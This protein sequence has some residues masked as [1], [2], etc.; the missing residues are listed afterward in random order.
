[1]QIGADASLFGSTDL[2]FR[3]SV[4]SEWIRI[5]MVNVTFVSATVTYNKKKTKKK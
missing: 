4:M 3:A 5:P 1:M 2:L